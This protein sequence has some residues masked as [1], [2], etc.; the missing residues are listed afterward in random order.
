MGGE[1]R[2]DEAEPAVSGMKA[3]EST[4][5]TLRAGHEES[6]AAAQDL[7]KKVE[8]AEAAEG[9]PLPSQEEADETAGTG[10]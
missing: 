10:I 9:K 3:S 6:L 2:S 8:E 4:S 5:E 1:N 7:V